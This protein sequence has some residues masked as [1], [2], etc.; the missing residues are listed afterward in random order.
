MCVSFLHFEVHG[1]GLFT[2]LWD[3]ISYNRVWVLLLCLMVWYFLQ[4]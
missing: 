1:M 3:G 2:D 4:W